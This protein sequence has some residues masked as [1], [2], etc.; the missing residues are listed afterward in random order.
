MIARRILL[1]AACAIGASAAALG[2]GDRAATRMALPEDAVAVVNGRA[3]STQEYQR[4]IEAVTADRRDSIN[5]ALRERVLDRLIDEELLVQ[6]GLSS[7]LAARD[8]R[9]RTNLS[10]AVID[11]VVTQAEHNA[12]TSEAALVAFYARESARFSTPL[13]IDTHILFFVG[14][15]SADRAATAVSKL[16]A[17]ESVASDPLPFPIAKG[18]MLAS[19]LRDYW[20]PAV[21]RKARK[22]PIGEWGSVVAA[23]GGHVVIRVLA[24][25]GGAAPALE[26]IRT[27]VERELIRRVGERGLREFLAGQR[28]AAAI[29]VM[30][31]PVP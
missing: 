7:E 13:E 18:P 17:G 27:V 26:N 30:Q 11:L 9:V 19:K 14:P 5:A 31:A 22:L 25:S 8:P 29:V 3:I 15:T 2:L 12:D 1:V 23:V 28:A 16:L 24:R 4:A 21:A 20:G 10:S 6:Y